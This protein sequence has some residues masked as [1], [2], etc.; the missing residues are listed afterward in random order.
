LANV[1]WRLGLV[2]PLGE[3]T[4]ESAALDRA[5]VTDA[6]ATLASTLALMAVVFLL[7]LLGTA[8][9][10]RQVLTRPIAALVA[11]TRAISSGHFDV[12][13]PDDRRDELGDLAASF[14]RMTGEIAMAR[15]GLER[16][17][18]ELTV[19]NAALEVEVAERRRAEEA[20]QERETQY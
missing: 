8:A 11:G 12:K 19:A 9:L 7:T 16:R 10:G 3:I 13:I 4:A 6:D 14:N 15:D 1:G 5:I 18:A 17:T 20:L 2:A